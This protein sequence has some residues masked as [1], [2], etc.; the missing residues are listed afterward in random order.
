MS[1]ANKVL[2]SSGLLIASQFVVRGMGLISTLIIVRLLTPED[3][4]VLAISMLVIAFTEMISMTGS[5]QYIHQKSEVSN[6]DVNTAWTANIIIKLAIAILILFI[7]PHAANYYED[8]RLQWSISILSSLMVMHA[9]S[10]PGV[11]LLERSINY[12]KS[13]SIDISKKLLSAIFTILFAWTLGDYRALIYGHISSGLL[14]LLL[15]YVLVNYRP[16]LS[17]ENI[18]EQ[19]KFSKYALFQ[20]A[21]GFFRAHIDTL[22]VSKFYST[23]ALGAYN[24]I[25]YVGVMPSSEIIMPALKP[26]LA[27]FAKKKDSKV[28]LL[29]QFTL[30]VLILSV[31][32]IPLGVFLSVNSYEIVSILFGGGWKTY[33]FIFEY[34]V[35]GTITSSFYVVSSQVLVACGYIKHSFRFNLVSFALLLGVL[36]SAI[37]LELRYFLVW[38]VSFEILSSFV[39]LNLVMIFVL[40]SNPFK[41]VV[42]LILN[43]IV[44]YIY[45]IFLYQYEFNQTYEFINLIVSGLLFCF[46]CIAINMIIF[47]VFWLKTPVGQ[48]LNYI[49]K[50]LTSRQ[51]SNFKAVLPFKR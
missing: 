3:F 22:V 35:L 45:A 39:L 27:T 40:K 7:A 25:K 41:L 6:S 17:L 49:A 46:G 48:H 2:K 12:K 20:G 43:F 26:M 21:M 8:Q 19:W 28:A 1:E 13:I 32:I 31:L 16:K 15:S 4:G 37:N 14:S 10:N 34:I 47:R 5:T 51:Y 44:Q 29:H 11:I 33:S 9:F 42:T 38:K 50:E 18:S 24:T 36:M 30:V 23:A